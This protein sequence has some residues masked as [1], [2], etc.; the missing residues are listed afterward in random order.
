MTKWTSYR[1]KYLLRINLRALSEN[2]PPGFEFRYLDIG[3]VGR[4]VLVAEPEMMTFADAPSRARRLLQRGDTLVSTV[5]TYLRAIWP[6]R[7]DGADL[8]ASTG[9]AVL[10][11][12]PQLDPNFL[13]WCA[14]SNPFVEEIVARS[15]GVSYPA[16]NAMEIGDLAI[17][18]P[19]LTEQEEIA[20]FLDAKT[21]RIDSLIEKKER[22]IGLLRARQAAVTGLTIKH[23]LDPLAP[24]RESGVEWVGSVPA[25]WDVRKI[26]R[27][28]RVRR[29]ASPRPI[30]DPL[31]FDDD[32][33]YAWVRISDV[34]SAG[35]YLHETEQRLSILGS[36]KS[37]RLEPGELFLSIAG[38]VGKPVITTI[39][40]CI[41]DGFVYFVGLGE[42]RE[43]LYYV[44]ASG[45]PYGGL[46]KLG[47]QL[48][49]NTDTVGEIRIPVPPREEQDAIV[50]YLNDESIKTS[51]LVATVRR[52]IDLLIEHRRALIT[53]A[54][55]GELDL[56][57]AA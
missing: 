5:R 45:E 19:S 12:V 38:S 54:V 9:F 37:V 30:D 16:I 28:C 51:K 18:L 49:L 34:T 15:V 35:K 17:G 43:F 6:L 36:S 42:N 2:T 57:E 3:T 40:C 23:G 25:H 33:E 41:H 21:A 55:T 13:G 20:D 7:D 44:L 14:Q 39:R 32:G 8:V 1:L 27:L 22:L 26:K 47:T 4:G 24:M 56:G 31:Y 53:A 29:G 46:G 48:N 11:P 50:A 52:Q 10:S